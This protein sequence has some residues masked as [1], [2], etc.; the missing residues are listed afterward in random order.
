MALSRPLGWPEVRER[1][2]EDA[3]FALDRDVTP[4]W[5]VVFRVR[6]IEPDIETLYADCPSCESLDGGFPRGGDLGIKQMWIA[7]RCAWWHP[8]K[9]RWQFR[10]PDEHRVSLV[11]EVAGVLTASPNP[12]GAREIEYALAGI[13]HVVSASVAVPLGDLQTAQVSLVIDDRASP[14][15]VHWLASAC[16]DRV[17]SQRMNRALSIIVHHP[18]DDESERLARA[19]R[20]SAT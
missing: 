19:I 5:S 18:A 12:L 17:L 2:G 10:V 15:Y 4:G 9:E 6:P 13:N 8:Y 20:D 14:M 7:C 3:I 16:L 1:F 11:E